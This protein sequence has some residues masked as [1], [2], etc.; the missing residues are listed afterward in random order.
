MTDVLGGW[1][2]V[3]FTLAILSFLYKD[4]PIYKL[5]EHIYVGVA[6]G[7]G[8]V[9]IV[10]QTLKPNFWDPVIPLF[11]TAPGGNWTRLGA[12]ILGIMFLTR[13]YKK[14]AWIST[15]P[16]AMIV[17]T[18]AALRMTG[19]ASSDLVG[20]LHGTMLSL[21]PATLPLFSWEKPALLNHLLII[22]GVV[23]VLS[24]FFFSLEQRGLLKI[25]GKTGIYFLMI[26]FGSSYGYTVMARVSLLIGRVTDLYT[27]STAHYGYA[28]IFCAILIGIII[29]FFQ[30]R[31]PRITQ[32]R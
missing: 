25:T 22:A 16:L 30:L 24:Y 7:Y 29:Y 3:F 31:T 5:A 28:T 9:L 2:V 18:F 32:P 27:Y 17:G 23:A 13:L 4:N 20:Q 11:T 15:W 14:T 1:L 10:T 6:A 8:F 21:N 19:L 12:G 26:T